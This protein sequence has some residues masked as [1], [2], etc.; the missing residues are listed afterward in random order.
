MKTTRNSL[1]ASAA[2]VAALLGGCTTPESR[3]KDSP[4]VFA[5][6]NPDQQALVKAGQI[7]PGFGMDAVKL[8]LGDPDRIL[9]ETNAGGSHEIWRYVTY[10]DYRGTIIFGGYY[11]R[12]QGWGGPYFWAGAPYYDGY[13]ARVHER[14][15]VIFDTA[16][17]VATIQ[18]DKP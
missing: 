1:L 6:L 16:G 11:H 8:A 4:A 3:I 12:Y 17:R 9:V 18:Q 15:R 5:R 13:P 14:I 2:L 10:E 7:A